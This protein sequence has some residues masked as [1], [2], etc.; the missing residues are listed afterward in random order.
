MAYGP[1]SVKHRL[2]NTMS[3]LVAG[4]LTEILLSIHS[5]WHERKGKDSYFLFF[6]QLQTASCYAQYPVHVCEF[7]GL[8]CKTFGSPRQG[9]KMANRQISAKSATPPSTL[10]YHVL[11]RLT[12]IVPTHTYCPP[13]CSSFSPNHSSQTNNRLRKSLYSFTLVT[14]SSLPSKGEVVLPG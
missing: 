1:V 14:F 8:Q 10:S 3:I 12:P 2:H 6:V 9:W 4:R 11:P 5:T 7:C 13:P